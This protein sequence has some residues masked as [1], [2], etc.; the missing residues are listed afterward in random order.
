MKSCIGCEYVDYD[1]AIVGYTKRYFAKCAITGLSLTSS[2]PSTKEL[3]VITPEIE[4]DACPIDERN[5]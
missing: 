4:V 5:T 2:H 1:E 3:E